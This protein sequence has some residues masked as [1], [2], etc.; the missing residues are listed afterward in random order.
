M[1][2]DLMKDNEKY[3]VFTEQYTDEESKDENNLHLLSG[4]TYM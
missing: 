1:L 4:M 3:F 2:R